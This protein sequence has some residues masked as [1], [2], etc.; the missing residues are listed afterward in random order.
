MKGLINIKND[1]NKCFLWCHVKHLNCVDKN[2]QR[3]TKKDR[4]IVKGLNY[5]IAKFPV[6]KIDYG[7]IEVL[8]EICVNVFCYENKVVHPVF[9][10]NQCFNDC[11]DLLLISNDFA[12]HYVY[13]KD[14]NRLMF[15]KTKNKN[16]KYFCKSCLQCF[17]SENVL[18]GH[19]K[20][21]LLI[22]G[23]QKCKIRERIY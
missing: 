6:S 5:S 15:N 13:I 11:L 22:N 12:S 1:D 8:N 9:L 16:K 4:E 17:S 14:F 20:Y 7:K 21:C 2:P 3:I 18:L 23:W 10:S 19:K